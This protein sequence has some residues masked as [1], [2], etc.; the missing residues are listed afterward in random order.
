MPFFLNFV[1]RYPYELGLTKSYFHCGYAHKVLNHFDPPDLSSIPGRLIPKTLKMVLDTSLH[2]TPLHFGVV[3]IEK[4]AFWSPSTTFANFS[5]I[6]ADGTTRWDDDIINRRYLGL[7]HVEHDESSSCRAA[8]TD[9][10]DHLSPLLPIVHRLRQ[11]FKA[12]SR[13]LT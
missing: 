10:P 1:S 2:N 5:S 3:A 9:I 12:T 6:R 4:G 8:S 7:T 11:V 13:I